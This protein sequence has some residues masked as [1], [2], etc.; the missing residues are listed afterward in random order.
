[1]EELNNKFYI[2]DEKKNGVVDIAKYQSHIDPALLKNV[3]TMNEKKNIDKPHSLKEINDIF[4]SLSGNNK[5]DTNNEK[6]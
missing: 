4:N 5:I 6:E 1:M 2:L 3:N